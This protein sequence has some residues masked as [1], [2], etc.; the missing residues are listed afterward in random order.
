MLLT[1]DIPEIRVTDCDTY[2]GTKQTMVTQTTC[3]LI[4]E[5]NDS[6]TDFIFAQKIPGEC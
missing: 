6:G 4:G 1:A 2:A 5:K 3:N